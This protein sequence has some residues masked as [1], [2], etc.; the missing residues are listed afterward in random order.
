[1]HMEPEYISHLDE[2]V[3]EVKVPEV[4]GF[5][6]KVGKYWQVVG[7]EVTEADWH[8]IGAIALI[9][10][11]SLAEHVDATATHDSKQSGDIMDETDE[12]AGYRDWHASALYAVLQL[13]DKTPNKDDC[14]NWK[15]SEPSKVA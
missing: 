11:F 15:L 8:V 6:V 14:K 4:L 10:A 2:D 3:A 9:Q 13:G 5:C 1:M 7:D 12:Q